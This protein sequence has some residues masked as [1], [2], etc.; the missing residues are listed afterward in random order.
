VGGVLAELGHWGGCCR[1]IA[2]WDARGGESGWGGNKLKLVAWAPISRRSNVTGHAR[3]KDGRIFP[4]PRLLGV[5]PVVWVNLSA[6]CLLK[7]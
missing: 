5:M 1:K 2:S 6:I 4:R 3:D 7:G